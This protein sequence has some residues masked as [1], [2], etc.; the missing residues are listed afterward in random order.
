MRFNNLG[1]VSIYN[2]N[3]FKCF[4]YCKFYLSSIFNN[5]GFV[6]VK[7]LNTLGNFFVWHFILV[8]H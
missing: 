8:W 6:L 7:N 5:F 1:F 3:Q 4:I 2:F